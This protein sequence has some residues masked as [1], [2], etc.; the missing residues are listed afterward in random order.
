[1]DR[2]KNNEVILLTPNYRWKVEALLHQ[3]I[4]SENTALLLA[5]ADLEITVPGFTFDIAGS[6]EVIIVRKKLEEREKYL[7]SIITL[8]NET[9]DRIS[10]SV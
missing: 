8:T 1:M 7:S 3:G 9:F 10:T 6:E 2:A 4:T 5:T